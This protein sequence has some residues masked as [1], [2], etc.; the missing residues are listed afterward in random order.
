M[1]SHI[2]THID[3]LY[4][5]PNPTEIYEIVKFDDGNEKYEQYENKWLIFGIWRGK[6]ALVNKVEP[7]IKINSISS[8]K[9]QMK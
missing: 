1:N 7:E 6:C 5:E 9:T 4:F 2:Y 3:W 8:W